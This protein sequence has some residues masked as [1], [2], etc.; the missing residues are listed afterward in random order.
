MHLHFT[1]RDRSVRCGFTLIELM[2]VVVLIGVVAT[3]AIPVFDRTLHSVRTEDAA[4]GLLATMHRA[5]A[6]A[7]SRAREHRLYLDEK[8]QRHWLER[9][10]IDEDGKRVF[11]PVADRD[12]GVT[13]LPD[14]LDLRRIKAHRD[15]KRNARYIRFLPSGVID[16]AEFRLRLPGPGRREYKFVTRGVDVRM[17]EPEA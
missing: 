6:L 9:E 15:G 5:Q 3:A 12:G 8:R 7:I 10:G 4:A 1:P 11:V 14:A 17:E 13:E 2:L 16:A